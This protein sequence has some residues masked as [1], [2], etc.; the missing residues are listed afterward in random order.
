MHQNAGWPRIR[1]HTAVISRMRVI[2]GRYGEGTACLI[3]ARINTTV[4]IEADHCIFVVPK[5]EA[6]LFGRLDEFTNQMHFTA[7]FYVQ[8]WRTVYNGVRVCKK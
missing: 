5:Y 8:F 3:F 6:G 4:L 2:N 7:I 1:R